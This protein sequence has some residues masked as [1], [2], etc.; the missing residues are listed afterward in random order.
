MKAAIKRLIRNTRF[1]PV[2]HIWWR[3]IRVRGE[4]GRNARDNSLAVR[5]MSRVLRKDSNYVDVGSSFGDLL[6]H[7][8][9]YAP[10]GLH[11]AIEPIPEIAAG[12]R[13]T[14]GRVT[15]LEMAASDAAGEAEFLHV[16]SN[17]G[18][19]GL[20]QRDYPSPDERVRRIRVRTARLDDVLPADLPVHLL[21]VDVEG[22]ELQVFRGAE[23]TLKTYR[24]FLLFEHGRGAADAYGTTP[25]MVHD[26]LA[27]ICGLK[28]STLEGWLRGDE[29][30]GREAFVALF[31]ALECNFLA[32][33]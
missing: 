8:R 3:R 31:K 10:R 17:S 11:F 32:H 33:P 14:F 22:A 15:V 26:F 2:A 5:I 16:T 28:V 19:S 27:G 7:A 24:P 12:L 20:R 1:E 23:R 21:K 4:S 6:W 9:R 29:P 13:A 25:E 30:L 18:Y